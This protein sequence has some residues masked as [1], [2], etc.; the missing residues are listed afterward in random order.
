MA[1]PT[2]RLTIA[3]RLRQ[4]VRASGQTV[5]AVAV[6]AGVPQPVLFRFVSGERDLTLRTAQKLADYFGLELRPRK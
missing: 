6:G 4:A 3:D 5:N 2:R 1:R